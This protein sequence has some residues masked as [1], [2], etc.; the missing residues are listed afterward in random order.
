MEGKAA[1]GG[2]S[3]Y[4]AS[5][6]MP[7]P[8]ACDSE[9]IGVIPWWKC[10]AAALKLK[11]LE[12]GVLLRWLLASMAGSRKERALALR[13]SRIPLCC[14]RH[15]HQHGEREPLLPPTQ[16]LFSLRVR[17]WG[18]HA[19]HHALGQAG[20]VSCGKQRGCRKAGP[21]GT[22]AAPSRPQDVLCPKMDLTAKHAHM[23]ASCGT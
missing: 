8:V 5:L 19:K 16:A 13:S 17:A 7:S 12:E 2:T 11:G 18:G 22:A 15:C 1:G 23:E 6:G 10:V 20:A 14:H 9:F 4:K 21:E 3:P